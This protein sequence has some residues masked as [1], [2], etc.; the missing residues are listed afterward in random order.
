MIGVWVGGGGGGGGVGI[1]YLDFEHIP[2]Q[3]G[4]EHE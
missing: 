2:K 3:N 1:W 4:I